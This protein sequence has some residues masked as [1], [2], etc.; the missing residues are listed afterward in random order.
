LEQEVVD[1]KTRLAGAH[2]GVVVTVKRHSQHHF[3]DVAAQ[4]T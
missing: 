4:G 1:A 3:F 2:E